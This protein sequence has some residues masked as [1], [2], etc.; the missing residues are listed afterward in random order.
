MSATRQKALLAYDEDA[1]HISRNPKPVLPVLDDVV[2]PG[3]GIMTRRVAHDEV[4]QLTAGFIVEVHPVVGGNPNVAFVVFINL[5]YAVVRHRVG[6][7]VLLEPYG[8]CGLA[9]GHGEAYQTIGAAR[10]DDAAA[11]LQQS[12]QAV[13]LARQRDVGEGEK[14]E[15]TAIAP[16]RQPEVGAGPDIAVAVG[17][18]CPDDVVAQRVGIA[19]VVG[20]MVDGPVGASDVQP[21]VGS[22]IEI[23]L[24]I[25]HQCLH[26]VARHAGYHI[27]LA[28]MGGVHAVE[29]SFGPNPQ[30]AAVVEQ[31][32][33]QRL[34]RG[35]KQLALQPMVVEDE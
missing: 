33:D 15:L 24:L 26:R 12:V 20:E 27:G 4:A 31:C 3:G 9:V 23:T 5:P 25:G 11:V 13:A 35:R 34:L 29:L 7:A 10:P 8:A 6:G 1:T 30:A 28:A 19:R 22:R 18:E 17:E 21:V 2:G 14:S 16:A 32:V